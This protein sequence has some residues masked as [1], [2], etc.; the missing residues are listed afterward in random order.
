MTEGQYRAIVA[1]M[2]FWTPKYPEFNLDAAIKDI[3]ITDS[4]EDVIHELWKAGWTVSDK[5]GLLWYSRKPKS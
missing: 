5:T 1:Y 3:G 4:R 2:N